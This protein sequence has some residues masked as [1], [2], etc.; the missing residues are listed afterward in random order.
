MVTLA[1]V[2]NSLQGAGNDVGRGC[3]GSCSFHQPVNKWCML[4][5]ESNEKGKTKR[6][7]QIPHTASDFLSFPKFL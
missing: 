7:I 1:P 2:R 5:K 4:K 3:L 6:I